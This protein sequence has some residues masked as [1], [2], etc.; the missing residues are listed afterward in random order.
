MGL[1]L[2]LFLQKSFIADFRSDSKCRSDKQVPSIWRG[3]VAGG[4]GGGGRGREGVGLQVHGIGGRRLVYKE[5]PEVGSNY[6]NSCFWW[7]RS[8]STG[9]IGLSVWSKS[10]ELAGKGSPRF[11]T[12][13]MESFSADL[14]PTIKSYWG[15]SHLEL[16]ILLRL[17]PG[18]R[19]EHLT[20]LLT[21]L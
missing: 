8:D 6:K 5:V 18:A 21:T 3:S 10:R 1:T 4:G 20:Y 12:P 14:L 17:N 16:F 2:W 11:P 13:M 9:S 7:F 15:E 19:G